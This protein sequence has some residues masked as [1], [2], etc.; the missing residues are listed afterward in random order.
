M[1]GDLSSAL[2]ALVIIGSILGLVWALWLVV[3]TVG[4]YLRLGDIRRLLEEL[5]DKG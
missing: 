2:A 3:F 1:I 4:V 5:V